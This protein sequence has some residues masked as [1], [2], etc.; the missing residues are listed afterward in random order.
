MS[1]RTP[2]LSII[3]TDILYIGWKQ[4]REYY[5][6]HYLFALHMCMPCFFVL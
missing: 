5:E 6:G 1:S 4:A 2:P 3:S